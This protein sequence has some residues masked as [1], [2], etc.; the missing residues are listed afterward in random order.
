VV[1]GRAVLCH[2][3]THTRRAL[4]AARRRLCFAARTLSTSPWKRGTLARLPAC[5]CAAAHARPVP[6]PLCPLQPAGAFHSACTCGGAAQIM[7]MGANAFN[8]PVEAWDVGQVTSMEVR[9]CPR[10]RGWD[11]GGGEGGT[12]N[13]ANSACACAGAA[14]SMFYS[15]SAFNQPVAAWDVGQVT[16]MR[17]RRRP[18]WEGLGG[19]GVVAGRAVLCHGS[20]NSACACGVVWR[21]PCSCTRTLSTSQWRRGT[22]AR[23]PAWRYAAALGGSRWGWGSW[24]G[25]GPFPLYQPLGVRVRW[26]RVCSK[27]GSGAALSI[28]PWLRGTLARSPR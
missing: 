15:A 17:V 26:R 4:A 10:R 2:W 24:P 1:A 5:G 11:G 18:R 22:L 14:Q 12:F 23:S 20:T 28:S 7:F 9:H 13:D 19:V 21:R 16:N 27:S 25:G 6:T 3:S 8:Q